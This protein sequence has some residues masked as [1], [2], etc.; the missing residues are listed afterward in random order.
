M[1]AGGYRLATAEIV[2]R[3][4]DHPSLL[5]SFVWQL[6]DLPPAFPALHRFLEFWRGNLDGEL[7]S[8]RVTAAE[9]IGPA[10]YRAVEHSISFH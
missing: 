2:Y 8:V 9:L 7:H 4:P 5:Q 10:K 1:L 3:M 6:Y